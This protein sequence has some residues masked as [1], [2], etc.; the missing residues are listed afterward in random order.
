MH[1]P[2]LAPTFAA[3]V[4]SS[5]VLPLPARAAAIASTL[6]STSTIDGA[7]ANAA[8]GFSLPALVSTCP[9][10]IRQL[11]PGT[12]FA[13]LR[14]P[15]QDCEFYDC[16]LA[17]PGWDAG[18]SG[19][20]GGLGEE[21]SGDDVDW[22]DFGD[23][24]G[25][26][27]DLEEQQEEQVH[28]PPCIICT[29]TSTANMLSRGHN[30]STAID[31]LATRCHED[32]GWR[33]GIVCQS[34]CYFAGRGYDGDV[35]CPGNT[36]YPTA[37]PTDVP[38]VS[39]VPSKM[40]TG[41]PSLG[42]TAGPSTGPS[43]TPSKAAPTRD[44]SN[45]DVNATYG[46]ATIEEEEEDIGSTSCETPYGPKEVGELYFTSD[47]CNYC[48]CQDGG[49]P[50][51]TALIC[52]GSRPASASAA[53]APPSASPSLASVISES[54][55]S[56]IVCPAD[57]LDCGNDITLSRDPSAGCEFRPTA[58]CPP[59]TMPP[60]TQYECEANF[61]GIYPVDMCLGFIWCRDGEYMAGPSVCPAGTLFDSSCQCCK[62][63]DEVTCEV[64]F[65]RVRRRN[66]YLTE[67]RRDGWPGPTKQQETSF[68]RKRSGGD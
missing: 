68:L 23:G 5:T 12:P 49:V 44:G 2:P 21:H 32:S 35:C 66:R 45:D 40:P 52:P 27:E 1:R 42:P 18:H 16:P 39:A 59:T 54:S 38:S 30:C 50:G 8:S 33:A 41:E 58:T 29:D 26:D 9:P 4:L 10:P 13:V 47:G 6:I 15:S 65:G 22:D 24:T 14:D 67:K 11:C 31:A 25:A 62:S 7:A 3:V 64:G 51:C 36:E 34:S 43:I 28:P 46:E 48:V 61:T 19:G 55:T 53:T 60:G 37:S 20:G 57:V 63:S 56:G 17:P